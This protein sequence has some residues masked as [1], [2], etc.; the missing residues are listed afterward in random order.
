M[1]SVNYNR[2]LECKNANFNVSH[3]SLGG[4]NVQRSVYPSMWRRRSF[5]RQS[6]M[7]R[8]T[9]LFAA[10]RTIDICWPLRLQRVSGRFLPLRC[11]LVWWLCASAHPDCFIYC[12]ILSVYGYGIFLQT[13]PIWD[14]AWKN[15]FG[16]TCRMRNEICWLYQRI[17]SLM[18]TF[19]F[20]FTVER[21]LC[22]WGRWCMD[23]VSTLSIIF[24]RV[25]VEY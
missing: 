14:L 3:C 20:S 5:P 17:P 21:F 11:W 13:R 4:A 22:V 6:R 24:Q 15:R 8:T 16:L 23:D 19:G 1:T 18:F 25:G 10:G 9:S 12:E 7:R 2:V